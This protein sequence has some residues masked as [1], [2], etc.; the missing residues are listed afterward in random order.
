LV[1]V[2]ELIEDPEFQQDAPLVQRTL[3]IIIVRDWLDGDNIMCD[4]RTGDSDRE[5]SPSGLT[6]KFEHV[7]E[8][9]YD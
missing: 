3:V 1:C 5:N 4:A 2:L 8:V 6:A 7:E 9:G